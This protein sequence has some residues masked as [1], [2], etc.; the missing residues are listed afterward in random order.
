MAMAF[1]GCTRWT[2]SCLF[3]S[4]VA[5]ISC[6]GDQPTVPLD[7][8]YPTTISALEPAELLVRKQIFAERNP[9]ICS[10]LDKFGLT[11]GDCGEGPALGTQ[12]TAELIE[13]AKRTLVGNSDFT[14]VM[15]P[16]ELHVEEV[17]RGN[18]IMIDFAIQT[19]S[20][21][22]VE[23]TW[24]RVWMD[25]LGVRSIRGYHF[26]EIRVPKSVLTSTQ[27]QASLIG[28]EIPWADLEGEHVHTVEQKDFSE[29]PVKVVF[30]KHSS[31][32]IE[33]HLAW[34]VPVTEMWWVFVDAVTGE[35]VGMWRWV[36][37]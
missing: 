14:G 12:D 19:Y 4:L 24:I 15:S 34:R 9:Q 10:S 22:P 23:M 35:Q 29:A 33:L 16:D 8:N 31:D 6:E 1:R 27:A 17:Y 30:P 25:S 2:H 13:E 18:S 21:L 36:I 37:F 3:L 7:P 28:L 5:L 11:W 20:E 32:N 26:P